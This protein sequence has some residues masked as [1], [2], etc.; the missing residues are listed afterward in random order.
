LLSVLEKLAV[1]A[2]AQYVGAEEVHGTSCHKFSVR[3]DSMPALTVWVDGEY[4]RRI[5]TTDRAAR[6]VGREQVTLA[7]TKELTTDLLDLGVSL[8]DLDCARLPGRAPA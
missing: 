5:R 3:R 4:V 7:V 6:K 8:Q 1:G 2:E